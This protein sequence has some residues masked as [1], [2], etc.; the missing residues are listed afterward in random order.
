MN[1]LGR[2]AEIKILRE[3]INSP[4]AEMISVFGRRRIGKTFLIRATYDREI[5]F[6]MTGILNGTMKDQLWLFTSKLQELSN[7]PIPI[8]TP[9]NWIEAF[10]LL[11]TYLTA[12]R[13]K[14]R[15]IFFD[16]VPWIATPR[17]GFLEALGHFWNDWMSKQNMV[18][19]LCGSA[20]AW[21]I[22]KVLSQKGSLHNR[23]T[24]QIHLQPFTLA[25]TE[26]FLSNQKV[27]LNRYQISLIYMTMGGVPHYL[28]SIQPG[29][30]A[31]QN[32][33]LLTSNPSGLLRLEFDNLYAALFKNHDKYILVIRALSTKWKGL[34]RNEIIQKSGIPNGGGLTDILRDLELS[35]F[36]TPTYPFNKKKRDT[37]YRLTDEYS[38]FYL[39]FIEGSR[40]NPGFW[41]QMGQKQTYKSW[42]GYAFENLCFK[43]INQIKHALGISG[44]YTEQSSFLQISNKT[45]P[46]AQIDLIMDRADNCINLCEAKFYDTAYTLDKKY[47]E[48]LKTKKDVFTNVTGSKKN[49][50]ITLITAYEL[51]HNANSIGLVDHNL[52]LDS[53]F[54]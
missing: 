51:K 38:L 47:A 6:E 17:S 22:D 45:N 2:E 48:S 4:N 20:T 40:P 28:K 11:R 25:E 8:K 12:K 14:S 30:S 24:R 39:K 52:T 42:S 5:I 15:V 19:V 1:I 37:L 32:I 27:N 36:I 35:S 23:V 34:T 46:G 18:I 49:I 44:V 31:A 13:Q 43:H 54:H 3:A 33:D 53:L 10:T 7:Q 26:R 21:M 16:E 50:F 9:D 29:M 41:L